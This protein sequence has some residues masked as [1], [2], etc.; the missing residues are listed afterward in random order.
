MLAQGMQNRLS[1]DGLVAR[2]LKIPDEKR[3]D[4]QQR[5]TQNAAGE[6]CVASAQAREEKRRARRA[7][8]R[9]LFPY[10]NVT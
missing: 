4:E 2:D 8:D 1:R 3:V 6:Q 10:L 7:L 9:Y 5:R